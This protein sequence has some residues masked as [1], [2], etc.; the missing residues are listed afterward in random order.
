MNQLENQE[1][2]D[3]LKREKDAVLILFGGAEDLYQLPEP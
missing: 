3:V 1:Q 2:L